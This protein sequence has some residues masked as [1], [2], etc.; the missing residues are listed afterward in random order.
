MEKD[1]LLPILTLAWEGREILAWGQVS[2]LYNQLKGQDVL[3]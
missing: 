3:R 1:V 2:L